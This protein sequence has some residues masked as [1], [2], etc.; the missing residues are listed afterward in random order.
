MS[1]RVIPVSKLAAMLIIALGLFTL[2][3]GLATDTLENTVAGL[4]I[5]VLGLALYSLLFRFARKVRREL[6]EEE[7]ARRGEAE[8][9]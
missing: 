3:G 4:A 8:R 1:V 2:L 9:T 7:P 6:E 5:T